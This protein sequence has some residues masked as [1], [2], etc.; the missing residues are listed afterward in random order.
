[1]VC[2]IHLIHLKG[3]NSNRERVCSS[4]R[5]FVAPKLANADDKI[6]N[7]GY[8]FIKVVKFDIKVYLILCVEKNITG[9]SQPTM[10][11]L[12]NVV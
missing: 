11:F 7:F 9:T 4:H 6:R 10:V 2:L 8:H 3:D 5:S 1:V 12:F